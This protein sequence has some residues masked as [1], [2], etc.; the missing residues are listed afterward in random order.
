MKKLFVLWTALVLSLCLFVIPTLAAGNFQLLFD[1]ESDQVFIRPDC[2]D[3][4]PSHT[5][6]GPL[7]GVGSLKVDITKYNENGIWNY[8]HYASEDYLPDGAAYDGYVFRMKTEVKE[9]GIFKLLVD[10]D[11]GRAE[12]GGDVVLIDM[13]GNNVTPE[14]ASAKAGAWN[15]FVMPA[16][17]DGY[18]FIPFSGNLVGSSFDPSKTK[19]LVVGFV[20]AQWLES[21]VHIDNLGYYKGNDYNAIISQQSQVKDTQ[22][23]QSTE[24]ANS[25][26][27]NPKTGDMNTV[28]YGISAGIAVLS[29][30]LVKR[31]KR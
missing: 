9:N 23:D 28:I 18:V 15:G 10:G 5:T 2:P 27:S 29:G 6:K 25:N 12:F 1:F 7:L 3:V 22:K 17:F 24:S 30:V 19:Q 21:T 20:E 4:V 11:Y 31:R 8:M 26:K 14:S 16:D 13:N